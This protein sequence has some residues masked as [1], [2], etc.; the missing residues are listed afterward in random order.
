MVKVNGR[1]L[2]GEGTFFYSR[3]RKLW[4][5]EGFIAQPD[6]TSERNRVFPNLTGAPINDNTAYR[7]LKKALRESG[8]NEQASFKDHMR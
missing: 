7:H 6:G 5:C 2:N 8:I 3:Y 4:R 1:R